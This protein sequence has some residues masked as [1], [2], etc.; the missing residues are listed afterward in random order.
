MSLDNCWCCA[1]IMGVVAG[2][3]AV[4]AVAGVIGVGAG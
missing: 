1:G 3:V 2:A 4:G